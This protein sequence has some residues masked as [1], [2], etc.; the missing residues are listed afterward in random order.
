MK[1]QRASWEASDLTAQQAGEGIVSCPAER[2][3]AVAASER[4]DPSFQSLKTSNLKQIT[5][6]VTLLILQM[7]KLRPREEKQL[8]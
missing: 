2:C 3:P 7:R 6:P 5:A 1:L 4:Q 8:A